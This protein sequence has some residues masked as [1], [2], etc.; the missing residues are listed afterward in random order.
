MPLA[1][2]ADHR[3][4]ADVVR[5]FA[6]GQGLREETRRAL[7][8]PPTETGAVWAQV[9][10]LGWAGLHLPEEHGGSG[11]GLAELA[12]VLEG[13]GTVVAS[14]PLLATAVA[15]AVVDRVGTEAQRAALLPRL[16]DGS[17]APSVAVGGGLLLGGGGGGPPTPPARRASPRR[18]P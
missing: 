4:L 11:Y 10:D 14:G 12:V 6:A 2:T 13:L 17:T 3:E 1:I 16:A 15:S 5:S 7:E 8:K 9:A 18:P